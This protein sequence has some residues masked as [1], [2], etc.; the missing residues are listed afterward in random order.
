MRSGSL[1]SVV[2]CLPLEAVEKAVAQGWESWSFL[3]GG[4]ALQQLA[5]HTAAQRVRRP[6][7][8]SRMHCFVV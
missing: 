1:I 8:E 6:E 4:Q 2:S 3:P 7:V 5:D